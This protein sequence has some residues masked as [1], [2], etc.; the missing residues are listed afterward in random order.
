M[1][2]GVLWSHMPHGAL[3]T[4]VEGRGGPTPV[5]EE[6]EEEGGELLLPAPKDSLGLTELG[7][8]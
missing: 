7:V 6:V 5:V 8:L 1:T 3:C 2:D 4:G